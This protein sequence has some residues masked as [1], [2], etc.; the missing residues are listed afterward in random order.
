M[1]TQYNLVDKTTDQMGI[2]MSL[3]GEPYWADFLIKEVEE[4]NIDQATADEWEERFDGY[5]MV[6][7][8]SEPA[9]AVADGNIDA[10]CI[11]SGAASDTS[12]DATADSDG[13]FCCGIKY[14]GTFSSQ[15]E[16]HAVWFS[17]TQ[18]DDWSATY[19]FSTGADDT[20]NW[21]TDDTS[22]TVSWDVERWL[23]KQQRAV[24]FYQNE[25]RFTKGD[26]IKPFTYQYTSD[27]L[28]QKNENLLNN[29]QIAE[30]AT[31]L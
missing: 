11:M 16:I 12:K 10:A 28:Y 5:K 22:F 7:T 21:R 9:V 3:S 29:F 4:A 6:W 2:S 24:E 15:P 26:W 25:Y 1:T 23:P 19:G 14:S 27:N 30:G 18:Y 17:K 8:F 13:G 20:A 31:A